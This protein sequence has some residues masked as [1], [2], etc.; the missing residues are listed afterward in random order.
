M[1]GRSFLGLKSTDSPLHWVLPVVPGLC[2]G[3]SSLFGGVG[4][5]AGVAALEAA[6]GRRCVWTTCQFLS[7]CGPGD[8]V[9]VDVELLVVGNLVTQGRAT[10]RVGDRLIL[11]VSA[12]LGD[13]SFPHQGQFV[14]MPEVPP[15]HDCPWRIALDHDESMSARVD[16]RPVK[17]SPWETL[18]G[19][20]KGD[21]QTTVWVRI[22]DFVGEYDA[23]MLSILGD[24]MFLGMG[25]ALG[26]AGGGSSLDNTMR[27]GRLVPTEW[28]LL[29]I[30]IQVAA[31]G[32]GH[33]AVNLFAEDGT[34]LAVAGQ[35]CAL[36]FWDNP[37]ER[38]LEPV[39]PPANRSAGQPA[40]Q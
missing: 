38:S 9:D 33:G 32:F 37:K 23:A 2:S 4:V 10:L 36:R 7:F 19:S 18:D 40:D 20:S 30:N 8:N 15:P 27:F 11:V 25:Q 26:I 13:R 17:F 14:T 5:A 3:R 1:D 21:G 6:S 39:H 34:L 24:F 16:Q 35:S 31:R 22:P 12:A 28:V 29:D